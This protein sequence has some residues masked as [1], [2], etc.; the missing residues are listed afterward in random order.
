MNTMLKSLL[1][2][3]GDYNGETLHGI[4]RG[5]LHNEY[6]H[7]RRSLDDIARRHQYAGPETLY[8]RYLNLTAH[9]RRVVGRPPTV[10]AGVPLHGWTACAILPIPEHQ[11]SPHNIAGGGAAL[12]VSRHAGAGFEELLGCV[13]L[14]VAGG[15]LQRCADGE[16]A[17]ECRPVLGPIWGYDDSVTCLIQHL[18][19]DL[20]HQVEGAID[21]TERE[22]DVC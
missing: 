7:E 6:Y 10:D 8:N 18:A 19:Q 20:A 14:R 21:P 2:A 11:V 9:A 22:R 5:E 15:E 17:K 1:K 12:L 13:G 4:R 16:F 3:Q